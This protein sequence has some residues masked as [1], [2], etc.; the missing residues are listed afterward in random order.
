MKSKV[1]LDT[2]VPAKAAT[3]PNLCPLEELAV[4]GKC[5][6]YIFELINGQTKLVL[7]ADYEIVKEYR[8]NVDKTS[9]MGILFL[10]WLDQYLGRIEMCDLLKLEKD[11]NGEY[12]F[13]PLDDDT[14]DFD[15]NDRKFI[16]LANFHL[17]KPPIIEGTD[18]K[19][20]GY[21][22]AFRKY[23]IEIHFLDEEYAQKMYKKKIIE[24]ERNS[25][26][27]S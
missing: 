13:F 9:N 2:N 12:V 23:G 10:K 16:A 19:W 1:I 22:V 6:E 17:E 4:Q 24:K 11:G 26:V 8:N 25:L 27:D 21:V 3:A 15:P 18:G 14:K 20:W 7:D 5:M